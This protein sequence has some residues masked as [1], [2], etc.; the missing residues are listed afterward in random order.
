M[1]TECATVPYQLFLQKSKARHERGKSIWEELKPVGDIG[2]NLKEPI[3]VSRIHSTI[4][5]I[6]LA[7]IR[8][9]LLN[10]YHENESFENPSKHF[11]LAVGLHVI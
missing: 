2:M 3:L 5:S 9:M 10:I 7:I 11:M 4:W 1:E 8:S 6:N